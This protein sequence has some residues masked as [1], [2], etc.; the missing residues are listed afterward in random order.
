MQLHRCTEMNTASQTYQKVIKNDIR[1][2]FNKRQSEVYEKHRQS[3][4]RASPIKNTTPLVRY[5][6]TIKMCI[7]GICVCVHPYVGK[8]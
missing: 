3:D 6:I 5:N 8:Y 4:I 2:S 7:V 1:E